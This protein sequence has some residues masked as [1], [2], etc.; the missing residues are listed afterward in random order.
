VFEQLVPQAAELVLLG[1]DA[2]GVL[3]DQVLEAAHPAVIERQ[4][5]ADR[6]LLA[7]TIVVRGRHLVEDRR[8]TS[9]VPGVIGLREQRDQLAE[10]LTEPGVGRLSRHEPITCTSWT[11]ADRRGVTVRSI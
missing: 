1:A 10:H 8:E 11:P 5:Q 7:V 6:L 3:E 2:V 9:R 4:D